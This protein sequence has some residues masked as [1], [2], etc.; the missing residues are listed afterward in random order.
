MLIE[1]LSAIDPKALI[2][3]GVALTIA[4][5][6]SLVAEADSP[7]LLFVAAIALVGAL[8]RRAVGQPAVSRQ[9][10][11][12]VGIGLASVAILFVAAMLGSTAAAAR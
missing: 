12:R 1:S 11:W 6:V 8:G 3:L 7:V 4:V 10:K 9:R 2:G 5:V